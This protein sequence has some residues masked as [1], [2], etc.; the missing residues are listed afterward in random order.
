[1][2]IICILKDRQITWAKCHFWKLHFKD[3]AVGY[4]SQP[5]HGAVPEAED[6]N[7]LETA[8]PVVTR[9]DF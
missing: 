2:V 3:D 7:G 9:P 5:L 4:V 6:F 1:M 8:A